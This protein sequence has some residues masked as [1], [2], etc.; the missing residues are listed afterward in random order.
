MK[1]LSEIIDSLVSRLKEINPSF[2][3][4][5]GTVIKDVMINVPA[6]E[7]SQIYDELNNLLEKFLLSP[8]SFTS[9]DLD[10]LGIS[11]A[12]PRK[13]GT[14]AT[15]RVT[16]IANNVTT[17]I[18]I[19]AG[20]VVGGAPNS[21]IS[22]ITF[23][24]QDSITIGSNDFNPYLNRYEKSGIVECN[25]IGSIGNVAPNQIST[26]LSTLDPRVIGVTNSESFSGGSDTETDEAYFSRLKLA[27]IGGTTVG[28]LPYLKLLIES[29]P[30]VLVSDYS[31]Y[32]PER[33]T[34]NP[35]G[36]VVDI[37][38]IS[39][40]E[41][42]V[43]ETL[44]IDSNGATPT[45][46]PVKKVVSLPNGVSPSWDITSDLRKSPLEKFL[47]VTTTSGNYSITYTYN[48]NI[49]DLNN[50]VNSEE[51]KPLT[52]DVLVREAFEVVV[53][54][55]TKVK[56]KL[57]YRLDEVKTNIITALENAIETLRFNQSIHLSDLVNVIENTSGVDYIETDSFKNL[58]LTMKIKDEY[59]N[60][61]DFTLVDFYSVDDKK[62]FTF[63]ADHAENFGITVE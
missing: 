53:Q 62:Y 39:P 25:V 15:G 1:N 2:N 58:I 16:F 23:T 11:I 44:Y 9:D 40:N 48:K 18:T 31:I 55:T 46:R 29:N 5:D 61:N 43:T 54:V 36:G 63:D 35:F 26:I 37:Y 52:L 56:A 50:W 13:L 7:M 33:N 42:Q 51:N 38:V 49:E 24:L 6:S 20:T 12:L 14:K 10:K 41:T 4:N 21:N 32:L 59:L 22:N 8:Q 47:F 60:Q 30:H 45:H 19:P 27:L 28:T 34:R 17:P 3:T 57:G